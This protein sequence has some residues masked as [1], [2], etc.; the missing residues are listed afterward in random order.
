MATLQRQVSIFDGHILDGYTRLA[1]FALVLLLSACASLSRP[2]VVPASLLEE[3]QPL[4]IPGLRTYPERLS[5]AAQPEAQAATRDTATAPVRLDETA[6]MTVAVSAG[7]PDSGTDAHFVPVSDEGPQDLLAISAGGDGGAFAAGLLTGWSEAGT[8]PRFA[9]VTGVSAGAIIAPFAFL[10]PRYDPVLREV[11]L[12]L[13]PEK[14]FRRRGVIAGLLGDGFSSS[15]PLEQ[16]LQRYITPEVLEDIASE[17]RNG[18]DLYIMTTDLDA[19]TPVIWSMGAIAASHVPDSLALFRKVILASVSIPTAVSPVLIDV[20]AGGRHFR[21]LHVDGGVAHQVFLPAPGSCAAGC[22]A[23]IIMNTHLEMQWSAT[24]RRTLKIGSRAVEAMMQGE[25]RNDLEHIH[26]ALEPLGAQMRVA[27]MAS[28]FNAPHPRPFD[29]AY[30][31]ALFAYGVQL[32]SSGHVW[33]VPQAQP[34]LQRQGPQQGSPA[35]ATPDPL[36]LSSAEV[37]GQ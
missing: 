33:H 3:A 21:E 2:D 18:R 1:L 14:L 34:S 36:L 23:F 29:S 16:L 37:E 7:A 19:A 12:S 10:G 13:R 5:G 4:G 22:R 32:A 31:R 17:Y 26:A 20:A 35:V 15:A 28:S 24:P 6:R 27:Y 9:V 11:T 30:M 25:A 8:R